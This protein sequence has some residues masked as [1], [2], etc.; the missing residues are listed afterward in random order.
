MKL[1][2]PRQRSDHARNSTKNLLTHGI[3]DA[4]VSLLNARNDAPALATIA[5]KPMGVRVPPCVPIN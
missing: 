3:G 4:F 2:I 5:G 1:P